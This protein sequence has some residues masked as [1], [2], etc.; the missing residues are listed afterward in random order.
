MP[1][2][3][4]ATG[5]IERANPQNSATA[6]ACGKSP[7]ESMHLVPQRNTCGENIAGE[8]NINHDRPGDDY[9]RESCV[10]LT[11]DPQQ[12]EKQHFWES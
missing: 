7:C 9:R 3:G 4:G 6:R 11:T 8:K 12:V 5:F 1:H 10:R 2:F